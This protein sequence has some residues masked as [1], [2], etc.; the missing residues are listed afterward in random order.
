M[1]KTYLIPAMQM[2]EAL[3]ATM[4]A[5]SLKFNEDSEKTV[6]GDKSLTKEAD[7]WNIWGA[8]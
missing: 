8:E 1:K 7:D 4:I 6:D 2:E 5:E 3:A